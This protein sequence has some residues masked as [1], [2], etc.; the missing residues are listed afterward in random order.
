MFNLE[1]R[2]I[3]I[4]NGHKRTFSG[5]VNIP[6]LDLEGVYCILVKKLIKLST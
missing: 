4:I 1:Q 2:S 5:D 6:Y 3:L